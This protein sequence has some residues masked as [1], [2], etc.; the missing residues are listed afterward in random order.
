MREMCKR[1]TVYPTMACNA[2]CVFCYYKDLGIQFQKPLDEVKKILW[3]LKNHYGM[4]YVDITGGEPTI[5]PYIKETV[6]YCNEINLKPTI[7]TNAQKPE[8]FPELIEA[9]LEDLLIS[10]HGVGKTYDKIVGKKGGFENVLR[11]I[12]TLEDVGFTFRTNSTMINYNYESLPELAEFF[13]DI[14]PR[15]ANFIAFNPHEGTLWAR[16]KT[17]KFQVKYSEIAPYLKETIDIL[18]ENG[19]WVNVRYFPLCILKGYEK[20]ISNLH[21]WEY[22]PYEWRYELSMSEIEKLSEEARNERAYGATDEEKVFNFL[23]KKQVVGLKKREIL[24]EIC[25]YPIKRV[26]GKRSRR[27]NIVQEVYYYFDF[28]RRSIKGH[29]NGNI[30]KDSCR[31]C[32]NFHICDGVYPQYA[33]SFGLDEFE[34]VEGDVYLRDPLFYRKEDMRWSKL[35]GE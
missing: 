19:I 8:I 9:G 2:N 30:W 13:K 26:M 21:Q 22:D 35:K 15:I 12:E 6:Q 31:D 29:M 1:G 5:Y 7:I 11:T 10:I 18:M 34:P 17:P 25:S 28:I 20:H 3:N 23:S 16:H 33:R 27:G 14:R 32:V 4:D 24:T